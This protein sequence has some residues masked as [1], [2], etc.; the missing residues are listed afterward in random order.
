MMVW[1]PVGHA[2]PRRWNG[3]AVGMKYPKGNEVTPVR[4]S[5]A[6]RALT[7]VAFGLVCVAV[8]GMAG[9]EAMALT[10]TALDDLVFGR[11]A[12]SVT[13]GGTVTVNPATGGK[14]VTGSVYDFGGAHQ[15]ARFR[16]YDDEAEEETLII[17]LP[18]QIT[19]T[20]GGGSMTVNAF[21]S[22]PSGSI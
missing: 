2:Q 6:R 21:T 8:Q 12:T 10:L 7:T 11:Y 14:S 19:I 16:A 22:D 3:F 17:T 13:Q 9:K 20:S 18:T 15:R 1:R 4:S 5:P